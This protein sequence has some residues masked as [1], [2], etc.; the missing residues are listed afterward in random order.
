MSDNLNS[1]NLLGPE[2]KHYY[3]GDTFTLRGR[4]PLDAS[5]VTLTIVSF[6]DRTKTFLTTTLKKRDDMWTLSPLTLEYPEGLYLGELCAYKGEDILSETE[7]T[8]HIAS[9]ALVRQR[10]EKMA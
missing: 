7:F 3:R 10:K 2:K 9:T 4:W 1:A 6:T 8:I 5:R